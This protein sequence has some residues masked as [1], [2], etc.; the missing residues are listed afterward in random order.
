MTKAFDLTVDQ[1]GIATLLFNLEGEKVNKFSPEVLDE[2]ERVIDY[3]AKDK[4]IRSMILKSGKP[5][6]FIAGADLNTFKQAEHKPEMINELIKK[7]HRVFDKIEHLPFPTIALIDGVCLG[8]G[9]ECALACTYRVATDNPKTSIGLPETQL[10]IFPGW[11]GTQRLPRLIGLQNALQ[12]I[13]TG[14]PVDGKK[15][16]KMG[17]VDAY[18]PKTFADERTYEFAKKIKIH[19]PKRKTSFMETLLEGNP[20]GRA[21]VFRKARENVLKAT[22]GNYPAPIIALDLIEETYTLPK[23]EGLKR[24]IEYFSNGVQKE[25]KNSI[26]LINLFFI[27]EALKKQAEAIN[28]EPVNVQAAGVLGAGTMGGGIA[29]A[30]S[31]ADIN[32]RMKD[33]NWDAVAKGYEEANKTFYKMVTK[34][35]LRPHEANQK[36]HR[37]IGTI[38][39]SGFKNCDFVIEAIVENIDVKRQVL[40]ELEEVVSP[41][42]IIATNTSSLTIEDIS[43]GM[44]YPERFVGMHFFNPVP[45]MPLV[46][47][48]AGPKTSPK[49][50]ATVLELCKRMKKTGIVVG[51]CPGFVVNRIFMNAAN[52]VLKMLEE[53]VPMKKIEDALEAY[54]LPMSPFLLID[55]IGI[56][57]TYKVSKQFEKSYGERMAIAPL[58]EKVYNMKLLGKKGGK[59][60]YIHGNGKPIPNPEIEKLITKKS[61]LSNEEIVQRP[62]FLMV[63]EAIRCLD[64]KIITNPGYLDMALIMGT[65]FPPFRGGLLRYAQDQ[66]LSHVYGK[67][68]E[69]A[70]KYG[71][72]YKPAPYLEKLDREGRIIF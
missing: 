28:A 68:Q 5:G 26:H 33:V 67:L 62:V 29:W 10:G 25:L 27:S 8:G 64:E 65:G 9:T 39:Y 47:V 2:L 13:L 18:F 34:K 43:A 46:E 60:F 15:A 22:K 50:V 40:K 16:S 31:N 23:K 4:N 24:E 7:G 69:F 56:D 52:E 49:A 70:E 44:K 20:L 66:G 14:K 53:G 21:L 17:L 36:F 6:I 41:E 58:L 48:V 61:D 19:R 30:F 38:D 55:E 42:T 37:I 57:V 63:N 11:G 54:G 12:I 51:D 71:S 35:R 59:G 45:L 32:I 1:D 3:A 72:R